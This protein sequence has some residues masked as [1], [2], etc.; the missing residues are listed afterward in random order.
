[1]EPDHSSSIAALRRIYPDIE[2]VAMPRRSR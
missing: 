2:I 1:M